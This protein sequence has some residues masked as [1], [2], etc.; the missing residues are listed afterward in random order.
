M[1]ASGA[2]K[3]STYDIQS[4][5]NNTNKYG[6]FYSQSCHAGQLEIVDEC[7]AEAWVNAEKAGGFAAIMNTGLG[8]GDTF[9]YDG[10][11]NRY[12]REFFDALFSH[13]E[14]ISRIGKAN[15]DSKED[16]Y[17]RIDEDK[18]YHVYYSILLFGDPYVKI[19]TNESNN[20]KN[21]NMNIIKPNNGIYLKNKKIIPFFTTI[22]IGTIDVEININNSENLNRVEL[23]I[24][25][26]FIKS[27]TSAP[28]IYTWENS[29]YGKYVIKAIAFDKYGENKEEEIYVLK[30][31]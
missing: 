20:E 10:P 29:K 18:M 22:V 3:L 4:I 13:K 1:S 5:L 24:N 19:I 27:Y 6:L 23:Y 17:F 12:A 7:V 30:I 11:S 8:Y 15:Q 21:I 31:I 26:E 2:M 28:Y 14:N 25:N 16:N 9:G